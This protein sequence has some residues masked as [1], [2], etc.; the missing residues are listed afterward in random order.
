M[1]QTLNKFQC[2]QFFTIWLTLI[3]SRK[4]FQ[5]IG[6]VSCATCEGSTDIMCFIQLTISWKVI[7]SEYIM[8][9]L[10]MQEDFIR[11]VS[12]QVAFEEES[13]QVHPVEAFKNEMIKMASAQL[14]SSHASMF[15]DETILRQ[16]HQVRIIPVTKVNYEWK[17]RSR[18][19]FVYGYENKVH[20]PN[21]SYPQ[22]CCWGCRIM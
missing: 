16:R 20:L 6:K 11:D 22:S 12:G 1:K 18:S 2:L 5:A 10:D 13:T 3:S 4:H 9:E 14:V 15:L 7:T 17:G 19:F 21:N 8:G